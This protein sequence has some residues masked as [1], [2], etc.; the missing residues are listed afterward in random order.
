MSNLF[1]SCRSI[2]STSDGSLCVYSTIM[3]GL[4]CFE[5][6]NAM[7]ALRSDPVAVVDDSYHQ[8]LRLVSTTIVPSESGT[9]TSAERA[10]LRH[11]LKIKAFCL[12]GLGSIRMAAAVKPHSTPVWLL[13]VLVHVYE[14]WFWWSEALEPG[15][16]ARWSTTSSTLR[17]ASESSRPPSLFSDPAVPALLWGVP[18]VT[19]Y[20]LV[21]FPPLWRRRRE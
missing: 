10:A 16:A 12:L 4:G 20:I 18:F 6:Y 21:N 14:S 15:A 8:T 9:Y 13:N 5:F 2:T 19:L 7:R 17:L 3:S 1:Q 11:L